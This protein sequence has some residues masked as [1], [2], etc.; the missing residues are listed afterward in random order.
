LG[1]GDSWTLARAIF[2]ER[3]A[4][5]RFPF[6]PMDFRQVLH[7]RNYPFPLCIAHVVLEPRPGPL[8]AKFGTSKRS[9]PVFIEGADDILLGTAS[10]GHNYDLKSS[11]GAQVLSYNSTAPAHVFG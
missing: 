9:D 11:I 2:E 3:V 6:P 5:S 8:Q 4:P 7:L 10:P 1:H